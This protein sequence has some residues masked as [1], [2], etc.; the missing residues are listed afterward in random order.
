MALVPRL[1]RDDRKD[2]WSGDAKASAQFSAAHGIGQGADRGN[3]LVRQLGPFASPDVFG[4]RDGF[5]MVRIDA[6]LIRSVRA[7]MVQFESIR[8][9]TMC[10]FP[11]E[12]MGFDPLPIDLEGAVLVPWLTAHAPQPNPAS[13]V[14]IDTV[15]RCFGVLMTVDK[16]ARL[17]L[18]VA[19]IVSVARPNTSALTASTLTEPF[20][21]GIVGMHRNCLPSRDEEGAVPEV[22]TVTVRRFAA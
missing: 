20:G 21:D 11:V 1:A 16:P 8:H 12:H 22:M 7:L 9:W 5:E 10:L 18:D 17:S 4:M 2:G 3:V 6:E 19:R 15:G 13:S 14:G